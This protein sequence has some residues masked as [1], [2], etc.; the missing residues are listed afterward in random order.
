[1]VYG[2][3]GVKMSLI[4]RGLLKI[5]E[6]R[7]NFGDRQLSE[8]AIKNISNLI[9]LSM[10]GIEDNSYIVYRTRHAKTK[11]NIPIF[12]SCI[13]SKLIVSR[14]LFC[15]S[16][17]FLKKKLTLYNNEISLPKLLCVVREIK[18]L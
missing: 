3:A 14:S 10:L 1:M 6:F 8:I 12:I 5:F 11:R 4:K 16:F 7:Y 2:I 9:S 15:A 13:R 17:F 18:L